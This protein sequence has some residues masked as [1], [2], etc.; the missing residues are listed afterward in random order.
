V[1][2]EVPA[3]WTDFFYRIELTGGR[4]SEVFRQPVYRR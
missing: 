4:Q 3:S 2:I 1:E